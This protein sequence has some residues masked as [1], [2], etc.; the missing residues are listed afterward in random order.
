VGV[1]Y[2]LGYPNPHVLGSFST[3]AS[4]FEPIVFHALF[5]SCHFPNETRTNKESKRI[6]KLKAS[7]GRRGLARGRRGEEKNVWIQ[8]GG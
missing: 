2:P 7:N 1:F 6:E 3:A 8:V 4:L 5:S